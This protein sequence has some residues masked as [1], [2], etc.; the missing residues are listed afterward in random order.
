VDAKPIPALVSVLTANAVTVWLLAS[1]RLTMFEL[2]LLITLELIALTLI[3]KAS[4]RWGRHARRKH[5][6]RFPRGLVGVLVSTLAMAGLAAALWPFQLMQMWLFGASM[7]DWQQ[8]L[9]PLRALAGSEVKWPLLITLAGALWDATRG[10][11][12]RNDQQAAGRLL[13]LVLGGFPFIA[14]LLL[15]AGATVR[16]ALRARDEGGVL[17]FQPYVYVLA[18]I[19]LGLMFG[20]ISLVGSLFSLGAAGWMLSFLSTKVLLETVAA[21]GVA[22]VRKKRA[23]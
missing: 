11:L 18:A 10:D 14:P 8:V 19:T 3:T 5:R 23:A 6:R 21:T 2:L 1:G 12:Q 22:K 20:G 15:A 16:A 17:R 9:D 7:D 4:E 13:T